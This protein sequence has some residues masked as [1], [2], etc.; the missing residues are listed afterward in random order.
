MNKEL[1]KHLESLYTFNQK[2]RTDFK[3]RKKE[4]GKFGNE[5]HYLLGFYK[6]QALAYKYI[7]E[8][9]NNNVQIKDI[10]Q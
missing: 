8:V 1:I 6:G 3:L 7:L 10:K 9:L 4:I 2:I 5:E